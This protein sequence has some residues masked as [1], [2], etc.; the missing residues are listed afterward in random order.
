MSKINFIEKGR[1]SENEMNS[2]TGGA[3]GTCPNKG[4]TYYCST[5]D[6]NKNPLHNISN[7]AY[8][9]HYCDNA[10]AVI[11]PNGTTIFSCSGE[12][13]KCCREKSK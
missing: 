11:D 3:A 10:F 8:N 12:G 13:E 4:N 6:T 9:Y 1:L 5:D 7:C 2:I